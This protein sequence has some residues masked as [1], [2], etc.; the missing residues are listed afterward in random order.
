M[1]GL[2][3]ELGV[4][5]E[6]KEECVSGLEQKP[7]RKAFQ[8][9]EVGGRQYKLKLTTPMIEMLE[10]KYKTNIMN[11]IMMDSMPPL[12]VMLTVAQ[13][14]IAP[15]EHGIS[16]NDVTKL[17]DKWTEEGGDQQTFLAQIIIPTMAVSGFFTEN[18]AEELMENLK[19][20][21]VTL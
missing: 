3:E 19:K 16:Y 10:K 21:S 12:S 18:Q 4:N 8:F 14:A 9:W 2:D 11:L 7:K 13:A 17:Y 1:A 15:W 6:R 20:M 5:T